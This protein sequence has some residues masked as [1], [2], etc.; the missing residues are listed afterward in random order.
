MWIEEVEVAIWSKRT[1]TWHFIGRREEEI[2]NSKS[3]AKEKAYHWWWRSFCC[4]NERGR[5]SWRVKRIVENWARTI[6]IKGI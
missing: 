1:W 3:K 4:N 2:E 5:E 6:S